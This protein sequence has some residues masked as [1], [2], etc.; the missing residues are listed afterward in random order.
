MGS[1]ECVEKE[2]KMCG[3]L[4]YMLLFMKAVVLIGIDKTVT[5]VN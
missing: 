3:V 5:Q 4:P 1:Q 2:Q